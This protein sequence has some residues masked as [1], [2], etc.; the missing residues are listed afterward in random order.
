MESN[1]N[2][3]MKKIDKCAPED[4]SSCGADCSSRINL[5]DKIIQ[6]TTDDGEQIDCL[7]ML[8]YVMESKDYIAVMPLKNNPEGDIYLFRMIKNRTELENIEDE[9]EYERAAEAFGIE[10]EKAQQQK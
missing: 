4:C 5:D 1:M 6:I 7:I 2:E 8:K 10:M 3:E 9:D